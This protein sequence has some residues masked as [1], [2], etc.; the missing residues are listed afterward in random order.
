M[1]SSTISMPDNRL[2]T[3][4]TEFDVLVIGSGP[5]GEGASMQ[6]T[7]G[8]QR[9]AIVEQFPLI[10]GACTHSGTIPS[11]ALRFAI[12]QVTEASRNRL[13]R[14]AGIRPRFSFG[15]LRR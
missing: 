5:G 8:R 4:E 13:F 7:K 12:F 10:G 14:E 3:L 2:P 15:D 11:K 6:A 9:V 1:F